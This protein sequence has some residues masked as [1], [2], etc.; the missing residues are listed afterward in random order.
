MAN[1]IP[2]RA[3]RP[4]KDKV[5]MVV[6]RSIA[7]YSRRI[8]NAKLETNPYSFLHVIKPDHFD[9]KKSKS[10]QLFKKV[11]AKFENFC[12]EEIIVKDDNE[13]F[14]VYRQVKPEGTYTG[15]IAG[16]SIDDYI[17]GKIKVHE[18]TLTKREKVFEKYL[19]ICD[20]NAEPVLLTYPDQ[21][22]IEQVVET[23]TEKEPLFD[24]STPDR[25]RHQLWSVDNYHNITEL[26][27]SFGEVDSVYIAD[28]H[29][30]SASS[31]LLGKHKR[32][33]NPSY[34][35]KEGYNYLL[36]YFIPESQ[37]AIYDFN[38]LVK[39]LNNKNVKDLISKISVHFK[40]EK[41]S[42]IYKPTCPH[43]FSMYLENEW[44]KLNLKSQEVA[45]SN[46][47]E[48]LD[49]SI[50][51]R[52]IL[53]PILGISDLK[54]NSRI[55]FLGGLKGME[56]LQKEVDK[57]KAKIAFGLYP[58]GVEQLKKIADTSNIMPPKTTWI[59]PKLR[60]GL[61][62]FELK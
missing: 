5:H 27:E 19:R 58:V 61:T 1:I 31:A 38:R 51:T 47:V 55:S 56:G 26:I 54:T 25:L 40:V 36:A 59:E 23:V 35:G 53:D 30:R 32:K 22:R 6:S 60:S 41:Q 11:R 3:I 46:P 9:K 7:V 44:Y 28:G 57:G 10:S 45:I 49:S 29:H 34:T 21:S 50:L 42:S 13:S 12:D 16:V 14:Y 43:E 18:Q 2:F 37:L 20:F 4:A 24:Y 15:I 17:N 39:D 8:L 52:Y 33:E 48:G 62:I